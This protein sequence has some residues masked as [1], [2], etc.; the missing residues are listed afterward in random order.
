MKAWLLLTY[1]IPREPTAG[2]VFV[3][4]KL[5][6]L[7]AIAV[8]DAVWVLP[9]SKRTEEQFQW[10]AAEIRELEGEAVVWEAEQLTPADRKHL[11]QQFI[12]AVEEEYAA[13]LAALKKKDCDLAAA[14]R[15]FQL[16]QARDFFASSLG[17][18]VRERLLAAKGDEP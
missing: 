4:R 3:W 18:Q 7:G 11:R 14:S 12:E 5:K 10:L 15:Q 16:A 1:R 13:L 2:R 17:R 8:Q 6:L 9:R